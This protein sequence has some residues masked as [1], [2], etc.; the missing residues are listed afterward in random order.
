[1]L[2][3]AILLISVISGNAQ[4]E[5]TICTSPVTVNLQAVYMPQANTVLIGGDG[6]TLLMSTDLGNSFTTIAL[7]S[8]EDIHA[9][10]FFN[11]LNGIMLLGSDFM[12][13]TDGGLTWNFISE[14][15]GNA[16]A[17]HFISPDAGFVA[18]DDGEAYSTN[19]GGMTWNFL[20]TGATERLEA[21]FFNNINDGYFGGRNQTSLHTDNGGQSFTQNVIPANGDVK[22]IQF[23]NPTTGFTCG[24]NGEVLFTSDGGATWIAQITPDNGPD[25]NALH[26]TDEMNG[27]CTGEGG[28][29]FH[30][31]DGGN[32][33]FNDI[34]NT[35][36]EISNIHLFDNFHGFAVGDNGR[37]LRL[38]DLATAVNEV[39]PGKKEELIIYPNPS[40]GI[41]NINSPEFTTADILS[42]TDITGKEV[43]RSGI[44]KENMQ[45]N[46]GNLALVP[47]IYFCRI[48]SKSQVQTG[49]L[50]IKN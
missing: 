37:I 47:G 27:W 30:T 11:P 8:F 13:S 32:S 10:Y 16:K 50:V 40:S 3:S 17:F 26:F 24:D 6:G 1:M 39:I 19:D 20:E 49:K 21:V 33:W 2:L 23:V 38:G 4:S 29:I 14:V 44:L 48:E 35:T 46:A 9:I 22:D 28:T 7:D 15:P 43:F 45:F 18:C 5:W 31:T 42:I 25:M 12:K 36:D 34:S 41:F